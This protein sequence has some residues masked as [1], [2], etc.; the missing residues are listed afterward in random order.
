MGLAFIAMTQIRAADVSDAAVIADIYAPYV[1]DTAI[2]FELTPP[3][4][5][6]VAD[7]LRA[8]SSKYP[9]LVALEDDQVVAYAYATSHHPR[10]AYRWSVNVSVYV[11]RDHHRRG[12]GRR[13]VL[14][15]LDELRARNFATVFAGVTLANEASSKLWKSLGFTSVGIF[16][17]A[18][19]KLGAWHDVE[20]WQL[21]LS[22]EPAPRGEPGSR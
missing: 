9:W 20:W 5:Q 10:E 14:A 15:L 3:T 11:H 12:Y 2:S 19:F 4:T 21:A 1:I 8:A 18:G 6:E 13:L 7:R 17:R 22:D 16:R